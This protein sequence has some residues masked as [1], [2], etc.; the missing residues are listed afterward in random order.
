MTGSRTPLRAWRGLPGFDG[1]WPVRP[2]L[3][4]IATNAWTR[5][6][7]DPDAGFRSATAPRPAPG[8]DEPHEPLAEAVWVEPY[9]GQQLGLADGY[10][11]TAFGT[12]PDFP[13]FGLAD[14]RPP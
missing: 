1:R 9:P 11:I 6:P 8:G 2:W 5:S 10:A 7:G 13:R 4:K 14:Q 3:Y 12:P